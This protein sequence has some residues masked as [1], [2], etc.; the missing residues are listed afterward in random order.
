MTV[1]KTE[2]RMGA[3]AV[4][5]GRGLLEKAGRDVKALGGGGKVMVVSQAGVAALYY[6][7][8]RRSLA[9]AGFQT[10]LHLLP[11]GERAKSQ[12]ELFR[13]YSALLDLDFERRD[14]LL[15]LGGGVVGDVTGFAA[16]TYM[17]GVPFVN[18]GTTLLAQVDSSVGGKTGINLPA[19]KNLVGAF[20]APRLVLSDVRTLGT[21]P[22]REFCASLA[23]VVKY[24]VIRDSSLFGFLEKNSGAILGKE[25]RPLEK[26]VTACARIKAQVVGRDE[27]E[28][29]GL[30]MILNYGHTFGHAFEQALGYRKL[31]HGEAVAAGM[32]CAADLAVRLKL[33]P[34]AARKRQTA[35]L[36]KFRLPVSLAGLGI[37]RDAAMKSMMRD[38][39]KRSGRLIFVLPVRIGKVVLKSDVPPALVREVIAAAGA[40]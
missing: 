40:I 30:R 17:R 29:R 32:A 25:G 5:I 27:F 28:T 26:V 31:V 9:R 33:F 13:I 19:G 21:L 35:L 4:R 16:S 8:V 23:E 24:G 15:A 39:K 37:R 6:E 34:P 12:A 18:A 11:Q 1:V 36:E 2:S 7:T 38:K 10:C 20:Y 14:V 3:Y 22:G